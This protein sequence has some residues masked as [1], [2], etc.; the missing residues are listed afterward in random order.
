MDRR[1]ALKILATGAGISLLGTGFYLYGNKMEKLKPK[2]DRI[3]A[4]LH[5]HLLR[6]TDRS[7]LESRLGSLRLN[8]SQP[9]L[10]GLTT[11]SI[12]NKLLSYY[13]IKDYFG[14]DNLG[15]KE[16][17]PGILGELSLG[18]N[19]GY[20]LNSQEVMVEH[21]ISALG[22]KEKITAKDSFEAVKEI[23]K[24]GGIAILN[25]PYVVPGGMT[26]YR[27]INKEEDTRINELAEVVDEVE[28]FNGQCISLIPYIIDMEEANEKAKRFAEVH[29]FKG[30]AASDSHFRLE[31]IL[32]SGIYIK[33]DNLN[34]KKL[35]EYIRNGEFESYGNGVNR[36]SFLRGHFSWLEYVI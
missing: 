29:S 18:Y 13:D 35:K 10:V 14:K 15:F 9:G 19:T 17:D 3:P 23:H 16:I 6:E 36:A 4:D 27:L 21:H 20:V 12:S 11:N 5:V 34:F 31:Q 33:K 30:I 22:C 26:R 24:Q 8:L 25:H 32:S 28:S 2:D 7:K 1:T